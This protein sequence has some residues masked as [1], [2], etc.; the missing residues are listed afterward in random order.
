MNITTHHCLQLCRK[1]RRNFWE[2]SSRLTNNWWTDPPIQI[3]IRIRTH[4]VKLWILFLYWSKWR[5]NKRRIVR[6]RNVPHLG[7]YLTRCLH[8]TS[9]GFGLIDHDGGSSGLLEPLPLEARHR[10]LKW[11]EPSGRSR[12]LLITLY[13][14]SVSKSLVCQY[15]GSFVLYLEIT[16]ATGGLTGNVSQYFHYNLSLIGTGEL[17]QENDLLFL[18]LDFVIMHLQTRNFQIIIICGS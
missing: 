10:A 8:N 11:W 3:S 16:E 12:R 6:I 4:C 13:C 17:T 2:T 18:R 9:R 7:W 5:F 1:S 15:L 14:P